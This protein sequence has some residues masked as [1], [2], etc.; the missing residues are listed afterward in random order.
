MQGRLVRI[1]ALDADAHWRDLWA[2]FGGGGGPDVWTYMPIGPFAGA[3]AFAA[4]MR[5]IESQSPAWVPF[6]ILD[7]ATGRAFGTAS[8]MRIDAANGTAEVG[9]IAYGAGLKRR[10]A[11]TEA[12]LLMA[13]RIFDELGYRRYEWKCDADNA[14]SRRAAERLGFTYEGTFRQ[15][16]VVKGRNRD[17]AWFSITDREWPKIAAGMER[18]LAPENFDALGRQRQSLKDV[19]AAQT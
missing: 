2:A 16:M 17:T 10:P 6:A 1:V 13:R 11:G 12:M 7:E 18:W 8:Y 9:C 19:I 4:G 15:H 5:W 14:P 3:T